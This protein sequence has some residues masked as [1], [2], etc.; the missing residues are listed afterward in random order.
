MGIRSNDN[1]DAIWSPPSNNEDESIKLIA[2]H[3]CNIEDTLMK[4]PEIT[5]IRIETAIH[6]IKNAFSIPKIK[7]KL[8]LFAGNSSKFSNG[9]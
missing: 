1:I 4:Y 5:I 2:T 3:Q 9:L 8:N 6:F 7:K